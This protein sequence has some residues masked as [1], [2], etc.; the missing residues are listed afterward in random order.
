MVTICL[1]FELSM[2]NLGLS[3]LP[4]RL[5]L[6]P[7]PEESYSGPI[8]LLPEVWFFYFCPSIQP[9]KWKSINLYT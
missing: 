7:W 5:N 9:F 2:R 4:L 6:V 3:M 8:R 1:L